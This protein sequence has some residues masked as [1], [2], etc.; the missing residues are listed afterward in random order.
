[1]T[2]S[3]ILIFLNEGREKFPLYPKTRAADPLL[4]VHYDVRN[5]HRRII[6]PGNLSL[7][8]KLY[9]FLAAMRLFVY[10]MK[11]ITKSAQ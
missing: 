3:G 2:E 1:M 7:T 6:D 11:R 8:G 10:F 4:P 9:V 5:N